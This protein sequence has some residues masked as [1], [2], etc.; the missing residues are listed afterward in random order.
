[1]FLALKLPGCILSMRFLS[2]LNL[3]ASLNMDLS[4]SGPV[5]GTLG[6]PLQLMDMTWVGEEEIMAGWA[7]E[8][9]LGARAPSHEAFITWRAIRRETWFTMGLCSCTRKPVLLSTSI[10]VSLRV[11]GW[12]ERKREPNSPC[13]SPI[14]SLAGVRIWN[15][16]SCH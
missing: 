5:L 8:R 7:R 3:T 10:P 12:R 16:C 1:M 2:I 15:N 4:V 6:Y 14:L 13:Q 11:D 9:A